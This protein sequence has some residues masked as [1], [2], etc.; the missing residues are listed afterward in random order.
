MNYRPT[1]FVPSNDD[2]E[3]KTLD[4]RNAIANRPGSI[5]DTRNFIKKY[6]GVDSFEVHGNYNPQYCHINEEFPNEIPY[7]ED[8]IRIAFLDIETDTAGGFADPEDPWQPITAIGVSVNDKTH[9]FGCKVYH[10]KSED[11]TYYHCETEADLLREFLRVWED[12]DPDII[13]GW[14]VQ[15]FDVPYMVNRITR[16]LNATQAKRLSPWKKFSY[17]NAIIHGKE[18]QAITFVGRSILDYMELYKK[19]TYTQRESYRLDH[20][21]HVEL[22]DKK[23]AYSEYESLGELY[24]KDYEKFIDYNIQDVELIKRLENKMKLLNMA[25]TLAYSA[26]VNYNDVFSQVRMWDTMIHNYLYARNIVIPEKDTGIKDSQYVGAYVKEPI[27]GM[28][29][30]IVSFDLA[31]MYPMLISQYNLSPETLITKEQLQA[32]KFTK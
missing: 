32:M 20:I 4:G 1:V 12:L 14:N 6:A 8:Q 15:F 16:V 9:V 13:T 25:I 2:S 29:E 30:W 26:K 31:S 23:L 10:A 5:S 24:E 3:W 7:V 17:R 22:E 27:V 21:A 19:F 18:Q 28:H 11:V